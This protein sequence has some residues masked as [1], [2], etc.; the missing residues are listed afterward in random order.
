MSAD[1]ILIGRIATLD[2]E[3]GFGWVEALAISG[4]EVLAAGSTA[5][6]EGLSGPRT[7]SIALGPDE[8]VVPGLTDAHIHLAGA[9]VARLKVDLDGSATLADGLELVRAAHDSERDPD[10]WIE[11]Y[12]W[13]PDRWAGWP[14]ADDL[15]RVAPGRRV[16]L[17][18]HD[19]HS[20]WVSQAALRA[21]GVTAAT[22]EPAGGAIRRRSDGTPTGVLH[23]SA[24][25][26]VTPHIPAPST[27]L[28]ESAVLALAAELV[29]LGVV[30]A[31]DPCELSPDPLIERAWPAYRRLADGGRLPIRLW[32]GFRD[33]ALAAALER[34]LRT[35]EPLGDDA[36]GLARVGWLKLFTDGSMGS[37]TARLYEPVFLGPGEAE[38]PGGSRGIWTTDPAEL[39]EM[40]DRASRAGIAT[41]IHAIGDEAVTAA[42]DAL[43]P[44]VGR[45]LAIPRVEHVQL[46]IDTDVLRF[47]SSGVAASVQ[48][49]H[50]HS[51]ADKA[52]LL[53]GERAEERGYPYG[54]LA[55]AGALIPFGTDAPTEPID[56]WPGVAMAVSRLDPRWA[57]PTAIGPHHAL[58]LDRSFRGACLDPALVEGTAQRGRL[59]AGQRADLAVIPAA[60]IDDPVEPGGALATARPRLVLIDG[61]IAFEG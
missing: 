17:W 57:D 27:E 47:G 4:R 2:G 40:A 10:A 15:E 30:A 3:R 7:R 5:E 1:L 52:R 51:D 55:A 38:P 58:G 34:G 21:A 43:E 61:R 56:P 44:T 53:W 41:M 6:I 60:A 50:L 13:D 31:H 33:D 46:A 49:C 9:A 25:G 22:A 19:Q 48:P 23:E 11:G 59:V 20:Y 14:T 28:V 29:R 16:A 8:V 32:A 36:D 39:A 35:G 24:A 26:L 12:G 37:R 54:A 42:L 45:T 18:A